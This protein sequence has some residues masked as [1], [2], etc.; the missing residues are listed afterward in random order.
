MRLLRNLAALLLGVLLLAAVAAAQNDEPPLG[1]VARQQSGKKATKS[2]DDDNFQRA[3][4]APDTKSADAK[5]DTAPKADAKDADKADAAPSED[6]K[7]LEKELADLKQKREV[8]AVQI[9]RLQS[10]IQSADDG[11]LRDSLATNEATYKQRLEEIDAQIP[12]LEKKL[13]AARAAQK[14]EPAE[15]EEE[16]KPAEPKSEDKSK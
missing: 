12:V 13:E 6:V 1:D 4:P 15:G 8:T 14:S 10:R 9:T 7:A 16:S 3:A 11:D 2:F 5:A